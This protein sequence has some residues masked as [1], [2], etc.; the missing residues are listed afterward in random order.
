MSFFN[1]YPYRNLTDLNLDWILKHFGQFVADI[2]ELKEWQTTHEK[3]YQELL[4]AWENFVAG[5]WSPELTATMNKWAAENLK[6]IIGEL[7]TKT[8]YFEITNSGNFVAYIPESWSEITFNTTEYD[9]STPLQ[10]QYGHLV[11]SY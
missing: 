9:Y 5:N 8:V 6:D 3:E 10:P 1:E 2:K 11:L 4:A 7:M